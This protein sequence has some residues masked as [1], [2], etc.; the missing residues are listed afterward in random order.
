M[1]I[2]RLEKARLYGMRHPTIYFLQVIYGWSEFCLADVERKRST[3]IKRKKS[4]TLFVFGQ[5]PF[6]VDEL[7]RSLQDECSE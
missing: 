4:A 6:N 7:V 5:K 2:V 3:H 1:D